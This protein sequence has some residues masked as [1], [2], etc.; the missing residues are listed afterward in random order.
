MRGAAEHKAK[1]PPSTFFCWGR[2]G[3]HGVAEAGA[4]PELA[5]LAGFALNAKLCLMAVEDVLHDGQTEPRAAAFARAAAVHAVEALGEARDV[6][7]LD[8]DAGFETDLC[9]V[10]VKQTDDFK[11]VLIEALIIGQRLAQVAQADNDDFAFLR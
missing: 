2:R 7:G 3:P 5:A 1:A 8:A 4:E 10:V 11:T 9:R 6:D